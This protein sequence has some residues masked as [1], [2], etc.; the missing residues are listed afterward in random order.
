M[1]QTEIICIGRLGEQYLRDAA[2]EYTKR[3]APYTKLS[4]TELKEERQRGSGSMAEAAV[5]TAES[6]RLLT[7]AGRSTDNTVAGRKQCSA[8]VQ[9]AYLVTLDSKGKR[10]TSE[11]FA[12]LVGL[13][14][15]GADGR[16]S[17]GAGLGPAEAKSRLVFLIGG[18][19]GLA[20]E[21]RTA[22]DLV[23]SFS[24]MTFP[25]QL[26]RIILLEQLYRAHKIL[27]GET[28]HK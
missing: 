13:V 11:E 7:A 2:A 20:D 8:S 19:L 14:G 10:I 3:L 25:H 18:S 28:Y 23:L 22:A 5:M 1:I 26:M 21:A 12:A 27:R 24:D 9:D 6:A 17:N 4:I 15:F 16:L